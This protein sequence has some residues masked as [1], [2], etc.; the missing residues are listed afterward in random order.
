M[1]RRL[2]FTWGLPA[3]LAV[4]AMPAAPAAAQER[5]GAEIH[6]GVG[7]ASSSNAPGHLTTAVVGGTL[8][9]TRGLGVGVQHVAGPGDALAPTRVGIPVRHGRLSY[10]AV[11]G[12]FRWYEDRPEGLYIEFGSGIMNRRIDQVW[13]EGRMIFRGEEP[14]LR[15]MALDALVGRRLLNRVGVKGGVTLGIS[16]LDRPVHMHFLVVATIGF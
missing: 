6:V 7:W 13:K 1:T 9:P 16:A 14:R 8:W 12:R 5:D 11:T 10:T 4:L 15:G 2:A 3:M